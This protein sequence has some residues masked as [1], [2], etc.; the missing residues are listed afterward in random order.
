MTTVICLKIPTLVSRGGRIT[1]AAIA[2][3]VRQNEIHTAEPLV[4]LP[5][6][7]GDETA[8]ENMKW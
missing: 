7:A 4:L 3:H 8:I 2:S 1:S 6:T 5:N